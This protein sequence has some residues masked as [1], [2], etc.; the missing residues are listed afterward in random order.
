MEHESE[1][2]LRPKATSRAAMNLLVDKKFLGFWVN[3][4][5]NNLIL[6]QLKEVKFNPSLNHQSI[7]TRVIT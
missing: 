4:G 6:E 5:Q 2:T 3:R 7:F 1:R